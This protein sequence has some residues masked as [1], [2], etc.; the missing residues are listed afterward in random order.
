MKELLE[1]LANIEHVEGVKQSFEDEG[2]VLE[3][4]VLMRQLTSLANLY[5]NVK[6][7][8]CEAKN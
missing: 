8:G 4:V 5:M 6:I 7:G 2:A 3:D 1:A